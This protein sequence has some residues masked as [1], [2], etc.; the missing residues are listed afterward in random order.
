V[1]NFRLVRPWWLKVGFLVLLGSPLATG[2][3]LH[4]TLHQAHLFRDLLEW[5][6]YAL[7]LWLFMFLCVGL[8]RVVTWIGWSFAIGLS[9]VFSGS[10]AAKSGAWTAVEAI[11]KALHLGAVPSASNPDLDM[12]YRL[13]VIV[14]STPLAIFAMQSFSAAEIVRWASSRATARRRGAKAAIAFAVAFRMF[15]HVSETFDCA[16]IAWKEENPQI[17]LPRFRDDWRGSVTG[18]LTFFSWF[19][20]AVW[21]WCVAMLLQTLVVI[22][23]IVQDFGSIASEGVI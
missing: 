6:L 20:E 4:P 18:R 2:G 13:I 9:V 5:S 12:A 8:E 11:A 22:P 7:F 1:I 23:R 15:Q 14:T 3:T 17:L 21:V 19:K 16:F 10:F